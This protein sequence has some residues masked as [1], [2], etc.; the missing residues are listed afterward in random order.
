MSGEGT[1]HHKTMSDFFTKLFDT[2]DYPARW[3]C[4]RWSPFEGWLHIL[5]DWTIFLAYVAIPLSLF[6]LV[7][8]R[9]DIRFPVVIWLFIFFILACG[10]THGVEAMIFWWPAY[11]FTGVLKAVT[12]IISVV[13]V[14]NLVRVMPTALKIPSLLG[15]NV[16]M[17]SSLELL[18]SERTRLSHLH[19]DLERRTAEVVLKERRL[20]DAVASARACAITFDTNSG[21]VM[22]EMGCSRMLEVAGLDWDACDFNWAKL[23]GEAN[24]TEFLRTAREACAKG[25]GFRITVPLFGQEGKWAIRVSLTP[26]PAISGQPCIMTGLIGVA[27]AEQMQAHIPAGH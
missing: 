13:T 26:E 27:P 23:M 7:S 16:A 18:E 25:E 11:R 2:S 14:V 3:T 24:A 9:K 1:A 19:A 17:A 5:S 4:G 20:R 12:A 8:R 10:I 22:W 21:K 15:E 6:V